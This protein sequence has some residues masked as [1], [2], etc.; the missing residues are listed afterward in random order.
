VIKNN[1]CCD[2]IQ[3]KQ[4]KD[5]ICVGG[6]VIECPKNNTQSIYENLNLLKEST[7][8]K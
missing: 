6:S 7:N 2:L 8:G 3:C 5:G 4:N 1:G